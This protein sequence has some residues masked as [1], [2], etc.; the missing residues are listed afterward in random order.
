MLEVVKNVRKWVILTT[1]SCSFSNCRCK[2]AAVKGLGC[3]KGPGP[4]PTPVLSPILPPAVP[5]ATTVILG[6]AKGEI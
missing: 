4:V 2:S 1:A 3:L 5:V 6:E